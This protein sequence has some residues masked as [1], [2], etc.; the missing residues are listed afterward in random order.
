MNQINPSEIKKPLRVPRLND[1][2][3][4][5]LMILAARASALGVFPFGV[6]FFAASF[7]KSVA[8]IG[9]A[10]AC[11]GIAMSSG[12]AALPKYMIALTAYWLFTRIY[13]KREDVIC[14]AACGISIL[15]G[16]G[17]MLI[18]EFN[19]LYD[20]FMLC[21]ESIISAL[22]YIV[23][24]RSNLMTDDR[25]KR[26]GMSQEEYIS[27]AISIGV[28]VAGLSGFALGP[29][30]LTNVF[31]VYAVMVCA[32]NTSL[33]TAGCSGLCI[34]FMSALSTSDAVI[35]M[36]VYGLSAVFASFM[37]TFKKAG[38]AIGY[39]SGTAVTLIYIRNMYDVPLSMLDT[40]IG[41]ALFLVT[42]S[43]VHEY[44]KSFFTRS[45]KVESVSPDL[46][47]REY[48]TMR[49][50][51]TAESFTSLR[52]CF[53]AVSEGRLKKY[54]D[55]VGVILDE[56]T[57]RICRGCR[58]CGKCWQTDFRR[59]YKNV[60]ELI[61][62]IE[63]SGRL[64][65]E[66]IPEHFC[67][68]CVR[69]DEFINEINHVYELYKRDVLRR[70]DA[71]ETRNL[72]AGQ[73]GEINSLLLGMAGDIEDGFTFLEQ[74]EER[75]V[76]E[77]DKN[78]IMPYE[79]SAI[80]STSGRC[81]VYLRL[82]PV[83]R[84]TAVEGIISEV[85]GRNVAYEETEGGLSKYVSKPKYTV[86]TAV[87]Q[88]PQDG[89]KENGD[90]ATSFVTGGSEFYAVLADGMGSGSEA[91]YES[92][93]ALRLL[94]SFLK[95]GF[96]VKTALGILNSAMCLNI[97]GETYSTVDIMRVDLYTG[98]AEFFKI[99]SAESLILSGDEVSVLSSSSVPVG[100]LSDIR[101]GSKKAELREGDIV[102]MMTDGITEAGCTVSRTDW[103]K[104]IMI[105][106]YAEMSELA[107][108]VMDT[109]LEKSRGIARDDM[110]VIAMR[111]M[112]C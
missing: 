32:L 40:V 84:R 92:S 7:D 95:A 87:L 48:L 56:T 16:G 31:A 72:V 60:L 102:L 50:R 83:I 21:T 62:V 90:S 46:R 98:E 10:A 27:A 80:E 38:C 103:I 67:E 110:S 43:V 20:V 107:K 73:Y 85:L 24:K 57:D 104:D 45:L 22:M 19:G 58:M 25:S 88:L 53:M 99:G 4:S 64:T 12:L 91:R 30:S 108:E 75:L 78:G 42:P 47:M 1:I 59:T 70:A 13:R 54:S 101:L 82:P 44:F 41:A 23:F 61:G 29:V 106:P 49:L 15:I 39:I 3:P 112:G 14:S 96:S 17:I 9:I 65:E 97:G 55:D 34:G 6:A 63:T 5:F 52:E 94:T 26:G 74:E 93:S 81:E 33:A 86:D 68:K 66:N 89:S 11:A 37:S 18:S 100:I 28:F 71:V 2:M 79:V 35:M 77:L 69:A 51:K 109:A 105:K 8:Y 36:G 76:D 111:V